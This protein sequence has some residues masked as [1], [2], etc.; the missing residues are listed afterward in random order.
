MWFNSPQPTIPLVNYQTLPVKLERSLNSNTD[1]SRSSRRSLIIFFF[2]T[3]DSQKNRGLEIEFMFDTRASC[4]IVVYRTVWELCQ[5]QHP[6]TI[7]K[8]T[9]V[10]KTYSGQTV[11]LTGYAIITFCYDPDGKFIFSLREWITEMRTQSLLGI[12]FCQKQVSGTFF[13]LPGI[14]IKNP[15]RS[16]CYGSF[17]QNLTLIYHKFWLL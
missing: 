5:L 14:E 6:I 15:P 17:H 3:G 16:I 2:A 4:S 1:K 9:K 13:A 8:S 7:Q 12:A 10:T 11:P